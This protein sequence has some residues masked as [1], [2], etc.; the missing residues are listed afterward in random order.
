MS[1]IG[2]RYSTAVR[3]RVGAVDI[4]RGAVMLLMAIDH[5]RI[6]ITNA[7]FD[8]TDLT[9][10]TAPYFFTRWVTHFCA[11]A[12]VFL[13]GTGAFLYGA[14][15]GR[16]QVSWFLLTRGL[17]L[18]LIE[19]TV[20]RLAWTFNVDYAHYTL[21]GV[22]WMLGWS[23]VVMAGLVYLPLTVIAA[24]ALIVIAGHNLSAYVLPPMLPAI[25]ASRWLWLWQIGYVGGVVPIASLTRLYVLFVLVPWVGVMAAGYAFGYVVRLP[26]P[27]RDRA[28]LLIGGAAIL[29]FVILRTFNIYGNPR[30]WAPQSTVLFSMLSFLNT[31]KYPASLQFLLMTLG[32]TIAVLPLLERAR[33]PVADAVALFGRVPFFYYLLHIPLIHTIACMLSL[34]RYGEVVAWLRLNHP[35]G[36]TDGPP[37][38]W[39][40][41][42]PVVYVVTLIVIVTLY[43]P[44]RWF[45]RVKRQGPAWL[46]Y[47]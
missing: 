27:R 8:P 23:M 14:R 33:G 13:A 34:A 43:F 26:Q 47:F 25:R 42:L 38:G 17:W 41:G 7:G 46:R 12:F 24:T 10:T 6:F 22:I 9:R 15:V 20:L 3:P 2:V 40:Y 11:P 37:A 29:L 21:A 1:D 45:D 5:V 44:C 30:P 36:L 19:L 16:K 18:V 39:G 4:A 31:A 35:L 32:P 28:C